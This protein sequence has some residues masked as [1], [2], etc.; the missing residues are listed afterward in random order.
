M[1]VPVREGTG[2]LDYEGTFT[3]SASGFNTTEAN[4]TVT[5]GNDI[6]DMDFVLF[7]EPAEPPPPPSATI[8]GM[9]HGGAGPSLPFSHQ[10]WEITSGNYTFTVGFNTSSSISYV[11]SS[12]TSGTV[13]LYLWGPEGTT[14]QLTAWIP[15]DLFPGPTFTVS[16]YPGPNPTPTLTSN[17]THWIVAI[18]YSHSS[19]S[20]TFQSEN[21]IP[22]YS[23]PMILIATFAS[24][25][26][27][28][29]LERKRRM[30]VLSQ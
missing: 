15:K 29:L 11:Y 12:V 2:G 1:V 6:V 7:P 20:I 21:A 27:V 4:S 19:R 18:D 3:V 16:S 10:I 30:R 8:M 28:V 26:A 23:G 13:S 24:A 25:T 17:T 14:G 22:E 9:V 5:I